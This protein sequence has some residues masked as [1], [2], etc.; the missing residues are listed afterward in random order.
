M[1][2][3]PS[4]RYHKDKEAVIIHSEAEEKA[5]GAGWVESPADVDAA[6]IAV[7]AEP[8]QEKPKPKRGRQKAEA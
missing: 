1:K 5:L 7:E 2:H 8:E 6:P 4:W 3:F